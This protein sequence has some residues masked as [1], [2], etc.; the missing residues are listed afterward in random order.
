V[1][2]RRNDLIRLITLAREGKVNVAAEKLHVSQP[3]LSRII[4]RLEEQFQGQL[5]ERIQRGVRLTPYGAF[6]VER[7]QHLLHELD[8]AD[9]EV[10]ALL[11]GIAGTLHVS[12]T[13]VWMQVIIPQVIAEF[14][15]DLP[16]IELVLTTKTYREGIEMLRE[17]VIDLHCGVFMNDSPLPNFLSREPATVMHFNVVAHER[18][19]I[20]EIERPNFHDLIEYPWIDYDFDAHGGS[21]DPLPSL[22]KVFRELEMHTGRRVETVLRSSTLSLALMQAGPYLAYLCSAVTRGRYNPPLK[23]VPVNAFQCHLEAGTVSRRASEAT[24]PLKRFKQILTKI[25]TC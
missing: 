20:H 15:R 10:N 24:P 23:V 14:Q 18:H 8:K 12:A 5:F 19:P 25:A 13:P 6:V 7:A 3:G 22:D 9:N 4:A 2:D 16:G 17:G 21:Q 1:F 11:G